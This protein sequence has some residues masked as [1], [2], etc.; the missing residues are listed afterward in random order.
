MLKA[1][2]LGEECNNASGKLVCH[3]CSKV[4]LCVDTSF[5]FVYHVMPNDETRSRFM[6]HCET[7]DHNVGEG[8]SKQLANKTKDMVSKVLGIDRHVGAGKV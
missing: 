7:H 8:T 1:L 3:C 6:L 4:A 5:F 2:T